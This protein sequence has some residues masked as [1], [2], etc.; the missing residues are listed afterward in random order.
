MFRPSTSVNHLDDNEFYIYLI[1]LSDTVFEETMPNWLKL[2][3]LIA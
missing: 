2:D 3:L 1:R